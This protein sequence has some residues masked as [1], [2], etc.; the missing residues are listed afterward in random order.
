MHKF[1]YRAPRFAV[2]FPVELKMANSLHI[3][4]CRDISEDGMKLEIR[5]PFPPDVCGEVSFSHQGLDFALRVRV[6]HAGL[7]YDGLK[8]IYQSKDQRTE[9]LH[10]ISRFA[11]PKRAVS[12]FLVGRDRPDFSVTEA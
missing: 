9:I 1:D 7:A 10:L 11:A 2:D 4:R 8:F 6:A 12:L 5:D 3:A